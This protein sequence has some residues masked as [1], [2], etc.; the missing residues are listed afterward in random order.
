MPPPPPPPPDPK[1]ILRGDMDDNV[2]S[3]LFRINSSVEHLYAGDGKGTVH[4]WDLKV[5]RIKSKLSDGNSSCFN[6][7]TINEADL[8]VQRRHG[9]IDIYSA[10]E[11]NWILSESFNYKYCSFCRS[12]LLPEEN[13]IL[14]PLD[15]SVVG[16]LSLKT[17]KMELTLDPL[18][19]PYGKKLGAVMAMKPLMNASDLVLV[20]Y[21]GGKLLLWDM[22]K[23]DVLSSLT[24]EQY[25]MT[26]DFDASLMRGIL[27]SASDKLEIF[28]VSPDHSLS[29]KSAK[30]LKHATGVSIVSIRPDKRIV[31]AG[32]WDGRMMLFS[33]KKMQPLAILKEHR[34]SLYDIVYSQSE[35][36]SYNTKCLMAAT[37]KDGCITMWD[38]YTSES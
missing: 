5:N 32:C 10:K 20:A 18:K 35:V 27:G 36:K 34:E 37:G 21:E 11:S 28:K 19:Q 6:L 30:I 14:V 1:F 33:W 2:H 13:A 22:R 25:P 8:V 23:N 15:S 9:I 29:H 4:I 38:I 26:F 3:L 17:L 31:T 7:H 12:Q 16:M 24:V